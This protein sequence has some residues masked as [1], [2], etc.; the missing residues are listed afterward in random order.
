M[1]NIINLFVGISL[2]FSLYNKISDIIIIIS[3]NISTYKYVLYVIKKVENII[4]VKICRIDC[5]SK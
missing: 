5:V 4:I 1:E 3:N 2:S